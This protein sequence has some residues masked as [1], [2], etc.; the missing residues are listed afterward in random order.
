MNRIY[1]HALCALA[2]CLTACGGGGG[3][4]SGDPLYVAPVATPPPVA[5]PA[6]SGAG[7]CTIGLYGDSILVDSTLIVDK[8][9][10]VDLRADRPGWVF[11]NHAV[12]GS[13]ATGSAGTFAPTE[14]VVV[15]EWAI[16]D[17]LDGYTDVTAPLTAMVKI[18]QG[19]G[20]TPVL[21]GPPLTQQGAI[22]VAEQ[23]Q[24]VAAATG[25]LWAAWPAVAPVS[26][27]DGIHPTDAMAQLLATALEQ[28]IDPVC[29]K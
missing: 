3:G 12:G 2:M 11:R 20:A 29:E 4:G 22:G 16:N 27:V 6:P 25:A 10:A 18:A 24:A 28:T 5:T 13:T 21:T 14:R 23:A 7:G 19:A 1:A 8:P 9:V 26:S 15:I 17:Y